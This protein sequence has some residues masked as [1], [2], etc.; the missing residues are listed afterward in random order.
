MVK[1]GKREILETEFINYFDVVVLPNDQLLCSYYHGKCLK[2]Y[3]KNFKLIKQILNINCNVFT[4]T[5]LAYNKEDKVLFIQIITNYSY[6]FLTEVYATDLNFNKTEH[7]NIS[8]QSTNLIGVPNLMPMCFK[9]KHLYLCDNQN[10][11]IEMF[12]ADLFLVK[13]LKIDYNPYDIKASNSMICVVSDNKCPGI[14]FYALNDLSPR[15]KFNHNNTRISVINSCFYEINPL[16]KAVFC[17]D[18]FGILKEEIRLENIDSFVT[19]VWNNSFLE[20]NG[21]MIMISNRNKKIIRFLL[22]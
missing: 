11:S 14:H 17:Y 5:K 7:Q 1:N 22:K 19:N 6:S 18:E 21:N 3:D 13:N 20:L 8:K 9:N 10:K 16:T 4:P 15:G 12:S 2:L